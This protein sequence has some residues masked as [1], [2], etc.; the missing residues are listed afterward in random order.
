MPPVS[1]PD[2]D[3]PSREGLAA[4]KTLT[5][6]ER[7]RSGDEA[8]MGCLFDRYLPP[9]RRWAR[10]RLPRW[11]REMRDTEDLVQESA[12][13]TLKHIHNFE[14]RRDGAFHAFLRKILQNLVLDEIRH[15]KRVPRDVLATSWP[16]LAPSPLEEVIGRD[17]LGRYEAALAGLRDDEREAVL[18]RIELGCS[19]AEI[20]SALGKPTSD[21]ARVMVSR[22]LVKVAKEMRGDA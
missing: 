2:P 15:A 6:L 16:D 12:I 5:L 20:A 14:P 4:E 19:Y 7:A 3:P 11:A 17:A 8:A 21:A 10:G 18:A 9:L 22:A 13:R 1:R